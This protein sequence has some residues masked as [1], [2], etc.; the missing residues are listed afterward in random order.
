M[1]SPR[2]LRGLHWPWASYVVNNLFSLFSARHVYSLKTRWFLFFP[3][4]MCKPCN[5]RCTT[6]IYFGGFS[7]LG[8]SQTV[9]NNVALAPK[10]WEM[11]QSGRFFDGGFGLSLSL[12]ARYTGWAAKNVQVADRAEPVPEPFCHLFFGTSRS[13]LESRATAS[14]LGTPQNLAVVVRL[15]GGWILVW[16]HVRWMGT[17]HLG[18][19]SSPGLDGKLLT[20]QSFTLFFSFMTI[21]NFGLDSIP[22]LFFFKFI[23]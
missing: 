18:I 22:L 8:G 14:A 16:T 1:L 19:L 3:A 2:G 7:L 9:L 17:L 23:K 21:R 6:C 20:F 15:V 13:C 5:C 10:W 4:L 11:R 12:S